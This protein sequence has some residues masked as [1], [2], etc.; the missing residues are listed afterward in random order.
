MAARRFALALLAGSFFPLTVAAQSA[1]SYPIKTVRI[2]VP[3]PPGGGI[4]I[5]GRAI[6]EELGA[7]MGQNVVVDNRS[8]ASTVIGAE[9]VARAPG[10]GYTLLVASQTTFA[11]VPHLRPKLPYD[12]VRDFEPISLLA[13]QPFLLVVHPS[14]PVRTLSELITAANA[15]PGRIN[16]AAPP[17]GSGAHLALE[18][19]KLQTGMSLHYIPY[20]G[21]APAVI[22]LLGGQIP[23]LFTTTSS[24][25]AH[26]LSKRVRAVAISALQRHPTLPE[27]PTMAETLPGFESSQWIALY[28]SRGTPQAIVERLNAAI[29]ATAG[30]TSF[31]ER[32]ASQGYDAQSSSPQQLIFR[33]RSELERYGKLIKAIGLKDEG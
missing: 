33:V 26:V 27:V 21:S 31:R 18:M 23:M 16:Y 22:D 10:D 15:Q 29:M 13:T 28:A 6:A 32:M 24:V 20:K 5:I 4:D 9:V 3:Y 17:T 25:H 7:R 1:G 11:I 30:A 14:L 2:V 8:G 19:V 12:P